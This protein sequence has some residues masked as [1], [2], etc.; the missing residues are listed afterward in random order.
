MFASVICFLILHADLEVFYSLVWKRSN[1]LTIWQTTWSQK[2]QNFKEIYRES[3]P[4]Q[5]IFQETFRM[6]EHENKRIWKTNDVYE[7]NIF[8]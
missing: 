3:N 5:R 8:N 2:E 7:H 4:V 6:M 1:S